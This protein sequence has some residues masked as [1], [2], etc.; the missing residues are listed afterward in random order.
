MPI[1]WC[2]VFHSD[3]HFSAGMGI[4]YSEI[5]DIQRVGPSL[6]QPVCPV[7]SCLSACLFATSASDQPVS[8]LPR[9]LF[10]YQPLTPALPQL[11]LRPLLLCTLRCLCVC[12][13]VLMQN[14][15]LLPCVWQ[16]QLYSL[17]CKELV[18]NRVS[19]LSTHQVYYSPYLLKTQSS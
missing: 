9:S 10:D 13:C 3:S 18:E 16:N 7:H 17:L 14:E 4:K 11:P 5:N 12:L 19:V 6:C 8:V 1:C 2:H 15:P